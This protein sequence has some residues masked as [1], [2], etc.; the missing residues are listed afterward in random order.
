M[1]ALAFVVCALTA[2]FH[3]QKVTLHFSED[4]DGRPVTPHMCLMRGQLRVAEWI[5]DHPDAEVRGGYSCGP[6]RQARR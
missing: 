2:P 5:A 6:Q 1:I 4:F 3:C